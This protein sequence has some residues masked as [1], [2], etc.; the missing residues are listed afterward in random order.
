M[1]VPSFVTD[2]VGL[3]QDVVIPGTAVMG[4]TGDCDL[5]SEPVDQ[6]SYRPNHDRR[7]VVEKYLLK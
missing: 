3:K 5:D 6:S 4:G 2:A 7:T 1:R